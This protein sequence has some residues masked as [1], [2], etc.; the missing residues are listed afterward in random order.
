MM[1]DDRLMTGNT[2]GAAICGALGVDPKR[3]ARVQIECRP[4][5]ASLVTIEKFVTNDEGALIKVV[6]F[7]TLS[8]RP[9]SDA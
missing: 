3:V 2:L 9:G 5:E 8:P 1:S 6:N 4:N 7:Y